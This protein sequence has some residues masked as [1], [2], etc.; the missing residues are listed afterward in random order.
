M[1]FRRSS[2]T[3]DFLRLWVMESAGSNAEENNAFCF[4]SSMLQ[5]MAEVISFI[6][7]EQ[8]LIYPYT[9]TSKKN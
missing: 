3:E 9:G 6:P 7:V 8:A 2:P 1:M 4:C 5:N